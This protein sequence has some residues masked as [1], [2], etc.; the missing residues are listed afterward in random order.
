MAKKY[1]MMEDTLVQG[2]G[3]F[4]GST[5]SGNMSS[6]VATRA[7][8]DAKDAAAEVRRQ[9]RLDALSKR[10]DALRESD[11]PEGIALRKQDY[12]YES[13]MK[14]GG[15]VSSASKRADGCATKGKTKG[16]II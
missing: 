6:K 3:R 5:G 1:G 2:A 13:G 12:G 4:G 7:A 14:K 16:R 10:R 9:R 8:V 11:S 15:K